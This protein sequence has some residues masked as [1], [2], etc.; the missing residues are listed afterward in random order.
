[1]GH[2]PCLKASVR[3]MHYMKRGKN[4]K[5]R[6]KERK[7]K[8]LHTHSLSPFPS[9]FL[10]P[11]FLIFLLSPS[12]ILFFS[13]SLTH[14]FLWSVCLV[15]AKPSPFICSPSQ[16]RPVSSSLCCKTFCRHNF[17]CRVKKLVCLSLSDIFG[18][19]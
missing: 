12:L 7:K 15:G 17:N 6:K 11:L 1:M 2:A 10:S 13:L 4:E 14:S 19:V 9:F 18:L 3:A 5:K 8:G 16:D